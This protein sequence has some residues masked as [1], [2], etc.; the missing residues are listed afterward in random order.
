ML[1]FWLYLV[2]EG[3]FARDT[4]SHSD[5]IVQNEWDLAISFYLLEEGCGFIIIIHII[6]HLI[7][8]ISAAI[9]V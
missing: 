2:P 6:T 4:S 5:S 1:L 7:L 3:A 9:L 8:V